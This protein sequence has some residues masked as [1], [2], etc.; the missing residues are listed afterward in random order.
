MLSTTY[1]FVC[2]VCGKTTT[3]RGDTNRP[4][5]N[6]RPPENPPSTWSFIHNQG[7]VCHE[8]EIQI[9]DKAPF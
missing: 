8:H 1:T 5:D 6:I 7:Y 2:S 4:G 9:K 3:V